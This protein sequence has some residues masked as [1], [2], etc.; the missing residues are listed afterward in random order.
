MVIHKK[1][2]Y[3]VRHG[4]ADF[5]KVIPL[6]YD[7]DVSL[8]ALGRQQALTIQPHIEKLPIQTVC[9]S[10]LRRALETKEIIA[11]NIKCP[12]IVIPELEECNGVIWEMMTSIENNP[13][14]LT[15]HVQDFMQRAVN[16]INKA[17]SYPGPVLI[18]AHGGV[19]WAMCYFM[20]IQQH[21]KFVE[22]CI[23]L[24]FHHNDHEWNVKR[25]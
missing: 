3:F 18:V 2:F 5:A 10:P 23:P 15:S 25:V 14:Q 20:K 12:H 17:L 4:E 7:G 22:N 19:H 6:D 16:G 24:H 8:N 9:V 13:Q 11:K 21:D 1:N